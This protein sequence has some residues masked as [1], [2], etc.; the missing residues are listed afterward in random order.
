MGNRTV[1]HPVVFFSVLLQKKTGKQ[2]SVLKDKE[3]TQI[4]K[5]EKKDKPKLVLKEELAVAMTILEE[6]EKH[7][8]SWPFLFPVNTKHFSTYKKVIKKPMDLSTIR[9]KLEGR[10]YKTKESFV[11]DVQTI[12][13][14]CK[15]FNE[16]QSPVGKAGHILRSYFERRWAELTST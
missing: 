1:S 10:I 15:A 16:D 8:Y 14:N 7:E 9:N 2:K 3:S 12:F 13:D 4:A 11:D 6:L 5:C